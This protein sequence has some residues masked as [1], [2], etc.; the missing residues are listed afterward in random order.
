MDVSLTKKQKLELYYYMKLNRSLEDRLVNLFKQ[1]KVVGGLYGSL[2][3]EATSVG[4]A[5]ALGPGDWIAPMIRNVGALLVRGYAPR[6]ILTQYMARYTS[7]TL[8][9]DGTSHFGD[10]KKRH[11]IS[12][13][14]MLGD[15]IP[16]MTGIAMAGR[17]LGQK[18]VTMTW[19]GDGGTSTGVFHEGLNLAA[20]QKAPL[21][22][23]VENNQW[24]Y[25][26]PVE[27]QVPLRDLA[28]RAKA[29][30]IKSAIVDGN[31][32]VAVERAA[33]EAIAHAR[34][35]NGPVLI[36]AKTMRMRGHAQHDSSEYVPKEMLDLWKRRDPLDRYERFLNE[37][38][39]WDE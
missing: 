32:V 21:V 7:P 14:S 38:K 15:L 35:G 26:T 27:R 33:R 22:L 6:D 9:K 12:P 37:N 28:D 31:D 1:N 24:A 10:L 2:G 36:E 29:Y 17:Y 11:V 16:V 8:G 4:T 13:I 25:S 23:I 30:G 18:I 39:L 20:V 3:Q 34:A 5:Y 19:I